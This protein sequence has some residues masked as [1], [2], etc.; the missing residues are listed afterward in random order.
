LSQGKFISTNF[1]A[2]SAAC[3][4][5]IFL[6]SKPGGQYHRLPLSLAQRCGSMSSAHPFRQKFTN[7]KSFTLR[8][9][10]VISLLAALGMATKPLLQPFSRLLLNVFLVPGGVLFGGLYMMWLTLS[11][12]MVGKPGS[13]TLAAFIQ[14]MVAFALGLSPAHGLLSAAVYV[15]PGLIV[16]L[17]FLIPGRTRSAQASRFLISCALANLSGIA[18][19]ALIRGFGQYPALLLMALGTISGGLGGLAAFLLA[20]KIPLRFQRSIPPDAGI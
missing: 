15:L 20:G 16:D 10:L 3:R 8:D 2:D 9:L 1:W 6:D 5:E 4:R 14:G 19:V 17:V 12:G 7:R 13:A 18:A 11:R